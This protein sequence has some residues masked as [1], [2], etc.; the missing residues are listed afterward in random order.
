MKVYLYMG[1]ALPLHGFELGQCAAD[2]KYISPEGRRFNTYA[3]A[4][5]QWR[6]DKAAG[7][8]RS[9]TRVQGS[10]RGRRGRPANTATPS[11]DPGQE[12]GPEPASLQQLLDWQRQL[13]AS[14]GTTKLHQAY[15]RALERV[16]RVTLQVR[17]TKFRL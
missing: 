9:R 14:I 3:K 10:K 4:Q 8:D 2:R 6:S 13:A 7:R 16:Q 5:E 11:T 12:D 17:S 15:F 1:Y